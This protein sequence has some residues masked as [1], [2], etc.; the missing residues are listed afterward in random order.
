MYHLYITGRNTITNHHLSY[1]SWFYLIFGSVGWHCSFIPISAL[2]PLV[3]SSAVN[4]AASISTGAVESLL[5][6]FSVAPN[7]SEFSML[8][9]LSAHQ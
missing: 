1:S 6:V 3:V 9:I 7:G 5:A 4:K 8:L 2:S